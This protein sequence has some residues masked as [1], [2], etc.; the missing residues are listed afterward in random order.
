VV[1]VIPKTEQS[2]YIAGVEVDG[3]GSL[4][5][6]SD[7]TDQFS[8]GIAEDG[9]KIDIKSINASTMGYIVNL[10]GKVEKVTILG[11]LSGIMAKGL[12]KTIEAGNVDNVVSTEGDIQTVKADYIKNLAAGKGVKDIQAN[13]IGYIRSLIGDITKVVSDQ[14]IESIW[15]G[16]NVKDVRATNGLID[17]IYASGSVSIIRAKNIGDIWA[18]VDIKDMNMDGGIQGEVFAK[19]DVSKINVTGNINLIEAMRDAKTISSQGNVEVI[20]HRDAVGIDGIDGI[21][22]YGRKYSKISENLEIVKIQ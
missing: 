6:G 7:S 12:I 1:E 13:G 19:R 20:A 3:K 5:F 21:V 2:Q 9:S 18:G 16:K 22:Y 10:S 4:Y 11:D 8:L 17:S 14:N 15:G